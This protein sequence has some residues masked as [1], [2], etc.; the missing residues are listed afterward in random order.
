MANGGHGHGHGHGHGRSHPGAHHGA[1][2]GAWT[3][4]KRWFADPRAMGSLV[5]SSA[6]LRRMISRGIVCGPDEVVVEFGG[7]TGAVT[8]AIL[9]AG[10]PAER[11]WSIELDSELA[12]FLAG[13]YPDVHVIHGDCRKIESMLPPELIGKVGTVV[14]GIPMVLLP[15]ELQRD[16]VATMTRIMVPGRGF[17]HYTFCF[18]SPL[19]RPK[20]GI[21][22]KR[23]GWTPLNVPPASVWRYAA[24]AN[25]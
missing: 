7:G 5:P 21:T 13:L 14:L 23:L 9:E 22:G 19:D 11:I 20:L 17:L 6:S 2:P 1:H 3:F 15:L 4:F 8:R 25:V 18:G 12:G 10:V 24:T 16:I